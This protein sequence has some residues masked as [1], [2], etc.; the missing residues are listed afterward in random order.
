MKDITKYNVRYSSPSVTDRGMMPL[1]NG[2]TGVSLWLTR[3]SVNFY[4]SRS[5]ALTEAERNVKL[6]MVSVSF[7][8]NILE[9][10]NF[11]QELILQKGKVVCFL[12]EGRKEAV[13]EAFVDSAADDIRL[14]FTAN[15]DLSVKAGYY[16]WRTEE[17]CDV[18]D[19]GSRQTKITGITESADR[20]ILKDD[21][22]LFYHKNEKSIIPHIL[23]QQGLSEYAD[24][25]SDD[26]TGRVFGGVMR[27]IPEAEE[28]GA[29]NEKGITASV[30]TCGR[31][32]ELTIKT[33]SDIPVDTDKYLSERINEGCVDFSEASK[34]TAEFWAEYFDKSY[35]YV[36]NDSPG[37]LTASDELQASRFENTEVNESPSD[38]T[39]A[40]ILSKYMNKCCA[41]A[42]YPLRFNGGH[43]NLS[44]GIPFGEASMPMSVSAR[45]PELPLLGRS[46]DE[47]CWGNMLLWQNE[48]HPY[49]GML[50]HNEC[51]DVKRFL[52]YYT[53]FSDINRAK[54][55]E[56]YGAEGEYN[57]EIMTSFGLMPNYV[58]GY[59]EGKPP[60][61]SDN[62]YGGAVDISPGLELSYFMLDYCIFSGDR[63][64]LSAR[65]LPFTRNLFRFIETRFRERENGKIVLAPLHAVETYWDTVNPVT[66]TA[67]IRAVIKKARETDMSEEYGEYFD[68]IW[69]MTPEIVYSESPF[70]RVVAPA[71]KY[72]EERHNVES[73]EIYAIFPFDN[74]IEEI[75]KETALNTYR[76]GLRVSGNYRSMVMGEDSSNPSYSGWHYEGI[77]AAI[78]GQTDDC[79]EILTANAAYKHINARFPAMWGP[80]YDSLPDTDHASNIVNLLQAM[81]MRREGRKIYL[82]PAFPKEWNLEF[83]LWPDNETWIKAEYRAGGKVKFESNNDRYIISTEKS[84]GGSGDEK[85]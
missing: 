5:D 8:P 16:S 21:K 42:K 17:N 35:I 15:F 53:S 81:V 20:I 49:F 29:C 22:I 27:L 84:F 74:M 9:F 43:F 79:R 34:R 18:R 50:A 58:Y 73:P 6:G 2:E 69:E 83:K 75:T 64:F 57:T 46:P 48:R 31:D 68:R 1:G 13:I 30:R 25:V 71:E 12:R 19:F 26:I 10:E 65:V 28:I 7:L 14:R 4:I 24:C 51:G 63:D 40:Y 44:V 67:G 39:R 33:F 56:Y 60:G 66:V 70:G 45:P 37:K 47:R 41:G 62:R 76:N 61:Y 52:E 55:K 82:L 23:K 80:A 85:S 3:Q 36:E 77:V 54:A 38:V 11:S 78:L 59:T 72:S 32:I